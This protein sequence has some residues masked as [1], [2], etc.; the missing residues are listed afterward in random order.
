[1]NSVILLCESVISFLQIGIGEGI[2]TAVNN[3]QEDILLLHVIDA[4]INKFWQSSISK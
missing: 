3:D 1:M 2:L 4:N